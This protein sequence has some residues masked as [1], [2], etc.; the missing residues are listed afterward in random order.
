MNWGDTPLLKKELSKYEFR[1]NGKTMKRI[2]PIPTQSLYR[3]Q[4]VCKT[5]FNGLDPKKKEVYYHRKAN[6]GD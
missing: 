6:S 1:N 2:R 5:Q 3:R 4:S